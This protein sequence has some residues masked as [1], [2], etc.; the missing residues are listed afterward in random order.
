VTQEIGF[1]VP[2]NHFGAKNVNF[3]APIAIVEV[4]VYA[5]RSRYGLVRQDVGLQVS[6]NHSGKKSVDF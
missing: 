2:N 4:K 6:S 1:L 5:F 3:Q